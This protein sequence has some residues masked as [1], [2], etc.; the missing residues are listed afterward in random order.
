MY[1]NT[2][3]PILHP[4][5]PQLK[6]GQEPSSGQWNMSSSDVKHSWEGDL[7]NSVG[8]APYS[9]SLL[10]LLWKPVNMAVPSSRSLRDCEDQS[11]LITH[12]LVSK[13]RWM[14]SH[15]PW[16]C[17]L[18]HY[19]A[20]LSGLPSAPW[21]LISGILQSLPSAFFLGVKLLH[22]LALLLILSF[23]HIFIFKSMEGPCMS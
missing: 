18:P 7:R 14:W 10:L 9:F 21:I 3:S 2:S 8:F 15:E 23:I 6:C 13:H 11:T 1:F 4:A 20:C 19:L 12:Q 16:G 5:A 17:L 22:V